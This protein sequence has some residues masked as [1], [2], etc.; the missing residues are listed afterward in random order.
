[1]CLFVINDWFELFVLCLFVCLFLFV[2]SYVLF[3]CL[4]Y[5]LLFAFDYFLFDNIC[6]YTGSIK[7]CSIK[8]CKA[9][10]LTGKQ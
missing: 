10:H 6:R 2:W 1:M 8:A 3:V 4:I 9:C 7:A 5:F